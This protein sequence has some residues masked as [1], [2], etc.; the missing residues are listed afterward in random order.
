MTPKPPMPI[1]E[2]REVLLET[3]STQARQNPL[4]AAFLG[5]LLRDESF[6]RLL[7]EAAVQASEARGAE[8]SSRNMAILGFACGV[9]A[10]KPSF[11]EQFE[12]Q[13]EWSM[14]RPNFATGGEPCGVVADPVNFAGAVAGAESSSEVLM[15]LRFNPWARDVWHDA[16]GLIQGGDWR[17]GLLDVLSRR[18]FSH[19]AGSVPAS[20]VWVAAALSRVG[21]AE[22]VEA[23]VGDILNVALSDVSKVTNGFEAGLR[24]A[25]IDWAVLR[26]NDAI[27]LVLSGGGLRA[28][29]FQLG[30]VAYL[31]NTRQL[32]RVR[33]L[34]SVSGGS[35]LAAH[36]AVN[37][38][39]AVE[40]VEQF[41]TVAGGLVRFARS[42]IRDRV[43][44]SWIWSRLN[45]LAWFREWASRSSY[46]RAVY[47]RHFGKI[48]F[49]DLKKPQAPEVAFVATDSLRLERIAFTE[50]QVMRFP[51]FPKTIE[52]GLQTHVVAE[53][54][55]VP[56]ALGVAVSSCF[57]PVFPRMRLTHR[58]LGL[59]YSECM[60]QLFLNDGGVV[61][62]LGIE[63]LLALREAGW[64]ASSTV[65]VADAERPQ[66]E[67]PKRGPWADLAAQAA[68]LSQAAIELAKQRLGTDVHLIRLSKRQLDP[69]G[70]AFSTQTPLALFRTD[71][72]APSWQECQALMLHGFA[73]AAMDLGDPDDY[74][75]NSSDGRAL[76][77]SIL[78]NAGCSKML[79][80]PTE[81][82][83]KNS[84]KRPKWR[85]LLHATLFLIVAFGILASGGIAVKKFASLITRIWVVPA[86]SPSPSVFPFPGPGPFPC[87]PI[88]ASLKSE[89]LKELSRASPRTTQLVDPG[90]K[91]WSAE[92]P[93]KFAELL[94]KASPNLQA[95]ESTIASDSRS[96][97]EPLL[98]FIY[99]P[100][101]SGKT[102]LIEYL[103]QQRLAYLNLTTLRRDLVRGEAQWTERASELRIHGVEISWMRLKQGALDGNLDEV[104]TRLSGN[105]SN[106]SKGLLVD[107]IDEIH[108]DSA[109]ILLEFLEACAI[110]N[111]QQLIVVAGRGEGFRD[112][113]VKNDLRSSRAI[114][115]PNIYVG[116][117]PLLS[118][119]VGDYIR[120]KKGATGMP[121]NPDDT[122]ELVKGL[123]RLGEHHPFTRH[124]LYPGSLGNFAIDNIGYSD[125][126]GHRLEALMF[127]D[128]LV[129]NR[130][131]HNRPIL[132]DT[133]AWILYRD[134]LIQIARRY[135]QDTPE[136]TF[137]VGPEDTVC[138]TDGKANFEVN[139]ASVLMR[140]GL[141]DLNPIN[142]RH[143]EFSFWPKDVHS[144]LADG[145]L[146]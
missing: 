113:L 41:T 101:G 79:P 137:F 68:A 94:I 123:G 124:F 22:P 122:R 138:V 20:A 37:W 110:S 90:F 116:E 13:L 111:P 107:S 59:L 143:L 99:A 40:S 131:T 55:G 15:P 97:R 65:L 98:F 14:G 8:R 139:V 18:T 112:F 28:T 3:A 25:A 38:A 133:S 73:A 9:E 136:G 125:L 53:S 75:R 60:D 2:A 74:P 4:V 23:T 66:G 85:L 86:P 142:T 109:V 36:L 10:L 132:A 91:L 134:T 92:G 105:A 54:T 93:A 1:E 146:Q 145:E 51:V 135:V 71:L 24:L 72:D 96:T 61:S 16:D 103:K 47:A 77:A 17:R 46:L 31:A 76:I 7:K 19:E 26:I 12:V 63:I 114:R 56:L 39:A 6:I 50:K 127:Q 78:S 29:L 117:E 62:N 52:Q 88:T 120:Y 44:I 106:L 128:L 27:T 70:L 144:F 21:W 43:M 95:L 89:K 108:P 84:N 64:A 104:V 121:V 82:D 87:M 126:D 141:V 83:L 67:R 11:A 69:P 33:A 81:A 130:E 45:P 119:F 58:E 34:V 129:R 115:L 100:G 102:P 35:I 140:S 42:N 32:R 30:I 118:W 5:W 57:P 48:R 80:V 49:G